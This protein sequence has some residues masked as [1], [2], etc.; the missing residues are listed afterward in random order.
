MRVSRHS[1]AIA[2]LWIAAAVLVMPVN[3][4]A[5]SANTGSVTGRVLDE[6][7]AAVPGATITAKNEATGLTRTTTSSANGT[8]RIGSL[9]AGSYEVSAPS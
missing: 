2:A 6:S 1:F 5:Q 9:P 7:K 3:G 4:W 8:Y